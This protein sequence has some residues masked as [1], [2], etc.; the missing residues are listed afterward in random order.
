M[1]ACSKKF[2]SFHA[3]LA[4]Q[5]LPLAKSPLQKQKKS[6]DKG[7]KE[8]KSAIMFSENRRDIHS[9]ISVHKRSA[10]KQFYFATTRVWLCSSSGL[11]NVKYSTT[12]DS[13]S[14]RYSY[15]V[16]FDSRAHSQEVVCS[17]PELSVCYSVPLKYSV[18]KNSP[19][20]LVRSTGTVCSANFMA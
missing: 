3:K 4:L 20:W 13:K 15:S 2:P 14:S 17:L 8:F 9:D 7:T 10:P 11:T 1:E 12:C 19:S 16:H 18:R 5:L 6:L